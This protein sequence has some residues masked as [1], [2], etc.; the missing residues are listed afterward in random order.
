MMVPDWIG[1]LD[2][3]FEAFERMVPSTTPKFS[4]NRE[5]RPV[6]RCGAAAAR[7]SAQALPQEVNAT[8]FSGTGR[9]VAVF[10]CRAANGITRNATSR[11]LQAK[12]RTTY[13]L[14]GL[15]TI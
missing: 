1:C 14:V 4:G 5:V 12:T 8:A 13:G 2:L 7:C 11:L 9:L 15:T 10:S 3:A 6:T